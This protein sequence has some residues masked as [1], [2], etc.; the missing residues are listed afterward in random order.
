VRFSLDSNILVYAVD[1]GTPEKRA[2][3]HEIVSRAVSLD[4]V[5]TVQALAE[6]LNVVRRKDPAS[7]PD[8]LAQAERW[9]TLFPVAATS[10]ELVARGAALASRHKLQLWDCVILQAARSLRA[11]IF[12]S[13][14]MQD[15]FSADGI[16]VLNPFLPANARN[17]ADLL[18]KDP[19]PV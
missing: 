18:E 16:T 6:F 13:E 15:G 11:S 5:L 1:T 8:A 4:A 3:A 2:I 9:A 12:L 7:L 19:D 10:W 14:D 17:L